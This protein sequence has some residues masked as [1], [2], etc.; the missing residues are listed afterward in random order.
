MVDAPIDVEIDGE[1]YRSAVDLVVTNREQTL[2]R[3]EM[4]R[5]LTGI[6]RAG[7]RFGGEALWRISAAAGGGVRR[8]QRDAS[9]CGD[10]KKKR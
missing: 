3:C 9:G 7:N 6:K 2:D 10:R 4:R 8:I 5:R 1:V